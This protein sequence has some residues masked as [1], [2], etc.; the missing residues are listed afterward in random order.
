MGD[1]FV[2]RRAP[3]YSPTFLAFGSI[4]QQIL[5]RKVLSMAGIQSALCDRYRYYRRDP[6]EGS[7]WV[8]KHPRP[9]V[10]GQVRAACQHPGTRRMYPRIGRY[11]RTSTVGKGSG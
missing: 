4:V 7:P 8:G 5:A 6:G 2:D 9:S 3:A 10:W 1:D 11:A